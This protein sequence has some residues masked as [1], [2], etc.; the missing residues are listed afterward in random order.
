[1]PKFS[2]II[3]VYN[4]APYLRE[5]L[6]SVLAQTFTDWEAICVNDG[7]MDG[8][9]AILDEY[10][11][12][13]SRFRV[14]HQSN[15]GVSAARNA[16]LDVATGEMVMFLDADDVWSSQCLETVA[17]V[18]ARFNDAEM[19]RFGGVNFTDEI[20]FNYD[21]ELPRVDI[22]DISKEI[23]MLDFFN[24]LFWGYAY[25]RETIGSRRF[26][27]Y[28][29]GEDRVF[30]NGIQLFSVSH[31]HAIDK[32]LYGYRQRASSQMH[33]VPSPQVIMEEMYHRRDIV[34]MIEASSKRVV[35][36]GSFWLEGYFTNCVGS[37]AAAKT[38]EER[39]RIWQ[40]WFN[41][42]CDMRSARGISRWTRFV[43]STCAAL[44][45]RPVWWLL[46]RAWPWYNRRGI[47]PRVLRKVA[48]MG[49]QGGL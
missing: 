41:C 39:S 48:G 6:D 25:R 27:S 19:I 16:A 9:G 26:P 18:S 29:R 30:L 8:S 31:I 40:A 4:V 35:Y 5:C 38:R 7:S 1:M 28:K 45:Y 34:K 20:V 37:L 32:V 46:C 36:K 3:P 33:T 17:G 11:A 43:Y 10:A 24:T 22:I 23:S 12:L 14:I 42:I 13:D 2:I 49:A 21:N 47:L 15:A 44:H